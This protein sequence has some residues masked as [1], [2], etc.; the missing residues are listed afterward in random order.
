M[1][2]SNYIVTVFFIAVLSYFLPLFMD[3][4]LIE[5]RPVER[6]RYSPVIE[7]FIYS[8]TD[9]ESKE[10]VFKVVGKD[11]ISED[12]F[13]RLLPFVH[14]SLLISKGTFPSKFE[15]YGKNPK[16]IRQNSQTLN[17]KY[18]ANKA[19]YIPLYILLDTDRKYDKVI[20]PPR[21][22]RLTDNSIDIL[23]L[24]TSSLDIEQTKALNYS[25]KALNFAF[26]AVKY[27]TNPSSLKPFDEGAFVVDSKD[28]IY[29]IR[30]DEGKIYVK[31]SGIIKKDIINIVVSEDPRRE[32]FALVVTKNELGLI[33]YGYKFITLNSDKYDPYSSNLNLRIDPVNKIL[34]FSS[35]ND[36]KTDVMDLNYT[37][38]KQNLTTLEPS[39][40]KR[41]IK[42]YIFP[43]ELK[44]SQKG[45]NHF[46]SFYIENFSI[47]SI[48]ISLLFAFLYFMI[49]LRTRQK[50]SAVDIF[51]I[52]LFGI[53]GFVAMTMYRRHT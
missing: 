35:T 20:Y 52:A 17:L 2:I 11:K 12:E 18:S 42:E 31:N 44:M 30:Q 33:D 27:Y 39:A 46:Y 19:K 40:S 32:F 24:E 15:E 1:R 47:K 50:Y 37:T 41:W 3:I 29:H 16:L 51:L 4:L 5:S 13:I 36:I 6:V 43:F 28:E 10:T 8:K 48:P 22:L 9:K 25:L 38:I 34:S 45:D 14:Y 49:V 53:Y 23:N 7:D 21:L 26:P